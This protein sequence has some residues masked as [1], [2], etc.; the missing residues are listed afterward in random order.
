[1]IF[2]EM[3]Y[4]CYESYPRINNQRMWMHAFMA[5]VF[6]ENIPVTS[7]CFMSSFQYFLKCSYLKSFDRENKDNV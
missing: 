6:K 3:N 2:A 1:M 5:N 7:F 4:S